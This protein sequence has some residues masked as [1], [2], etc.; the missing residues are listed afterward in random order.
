M[1]FFKEYVN[2]DFK[3]HIFL[4]SDRFLF[5]KNALLEV[6]IYKK[7]FENFKEFPGITKQ[8][9]TILNFVQHFFVCKLSCKLVPL[10]YRVI[11]SKVEP[12][13]FAKKAQII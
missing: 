13:L 4:Y 12:S 8:Y 7:L 9:K 2:L 6:E 3:G 5:F 10:C 1:L 11:P